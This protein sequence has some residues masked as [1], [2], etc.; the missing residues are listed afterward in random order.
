[1]RKLI[2]TGLILFVGLIASA[3]NTDLA[4]LEYTYFP[5]K[6]SDNSFRRFR[7]SLAFPIRLKNEGSYLVPGLE[8][9][10]VHFKYNDPEDFNTKVLD[11]FQSFTTTLGYT[12]KI[13]DA[14]RFGAQGGLKIASNF[15]R[16]KILNDDLIYTGTLFFM[17]TWENEDEVDTKRLILGLQ[18]STTTGFPFP[19][20]I[21]NYYKRWDE[22]WSYMV[23]TPKSNIK[24]YFNNKHSLEAFAM[25]DG[26]FANVQKNFDATPSGSVADELAESISMTVLLSGLEYQYKITEHLK[27]YVYAGHTILNDIRLRDADKNDVYTINETNTYYARSGLKFSIF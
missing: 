9:R 6:N 2:L 17:K 22:N 26:F 25:L 13:D 11:R 21:L 15:S 10:N 3:Q 8:Y 20:P 12:F 5:Q 4:R 24:Y 16:N 7:T 23:G 27:F 1:M 18:Y 14:W 19:L